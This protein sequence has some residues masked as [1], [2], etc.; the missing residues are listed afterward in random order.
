MLLLHIPGSPIPQPRHRVAVRGKNARAYIPS[1]HPVHAW[2]EAVRMSLVEQG[3]FDPAISSSHLIVMANFVLPR[4][5]SHY[6]KNGALTKSARP[7]PTG[8]RDG[9]VDNLLKPVL[10]V[11][12][13]EGVFLNDS[14]VVRAFDVSKR[15]CDEN[16][17]PFAKVCILTHVELFALLSGL[18]PKQIIFPGAL[19]YV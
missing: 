18:T 12:E 10:D 9:D 1:K 11:M 8:A 7:E 14:Q 17:E 4:P 5:A 13:A 15:F 16:E 19:C 3:V 2:R 6:T